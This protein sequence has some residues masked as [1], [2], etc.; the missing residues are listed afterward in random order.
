MSPDSQRHEASA[1]SGDDTAARHD[2][3]YL[4]RQ[5]LNQQRECS[6]SEKRCMNQLSSAGNRFCFCKTNGCPVVFHT[7]PAVQHFLAVPRL[8]RPS[9]LQSLSTQMQGRFQHGKIKAN[10]GKITLVSG[11][12][13]FK[14][15]GKVVIISTWID[16]FNISAI[17]VKNATSYLK[18]GDFSSNRFSIRRA[19]DAK[20][21]HNKHPPFRIRSGD[22]QLS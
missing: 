17:D 3:H 21:F 18:E 13:I 1:P 11:S 20:I 14:N 19:I 15:S 2:F 8:S 12:W 16:L 9:W 6:L 7:H 4:I 10:Q 22:C 5:F